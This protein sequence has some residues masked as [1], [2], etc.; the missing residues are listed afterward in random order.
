MT[1]AEVNAFLTDLAVNRHVAASTQNQALCALLFLYE[2]V[3]GRP[4]DRLGGV[5]RA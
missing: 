5:I 2:H 4:L 3:L 1:E